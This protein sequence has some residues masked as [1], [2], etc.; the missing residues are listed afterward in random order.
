MHTA[1][2]PLPER[3]AFLRIVQLDD[4]RRRLTRE[5]EPLAIPVRHIDILLRLVVPA[6]HIVSR[7]DRIEPAR[8]DVAVTDNS[9]R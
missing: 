4:Q 1:S 6:G 2:P 9:S 7:D 3:A 5:G 8:K